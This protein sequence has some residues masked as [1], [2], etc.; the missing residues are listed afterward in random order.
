M[1][2]KRQFT[3]TKCYVLKGLYGRQIFT[4]VSLFSYLGA[5]HAPPVYIN[6]LI[7]TPTS[8][9]DPVLVEATPGAGAGWIGLHPDAQRDLE[10]E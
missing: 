3:C 5:L 1:S 8:T 9:S 10:T 7:Y 2:K 6:T 4:L